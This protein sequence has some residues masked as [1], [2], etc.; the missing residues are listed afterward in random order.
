MV[1]SQLAGEVITLVTGSKWLL[2]L[3]CQIALLLSLPNL[4]KSICS[5]IIA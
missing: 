4:P 1:V 2:P 5:G 3:P